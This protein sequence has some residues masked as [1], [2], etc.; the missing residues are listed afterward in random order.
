VK[1][2]W[3]AALVNQAENDNDETHGMT[4]MTEER[5]RKLRRIK[6]PE[7]GIGM[8]IHSNE[9]TKNGVSRAAFLGSC[10]RTTTRI[11]AISDHILHESTADYPIKRKRRKTESC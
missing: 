9:S 1:A 10:P 4:T 3:T 11:I 5:R 2:L 6:I 8:A 7:K